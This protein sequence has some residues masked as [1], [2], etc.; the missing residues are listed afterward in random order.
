MT[1]EEELLVRS[2]VI[3]RKIGLDYYEATF[4]KFDMLVMYWDKGN[5]CDYKHHFFGLTR[6]VI[7]ECPYPASP[8]GLPRNPVWLQLMGA[9]EDGKLKDREKFLS[10]LERKITR[11]IKQFSKC[12]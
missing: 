12:T 9:I 6:E 7:C 1:K 2:L 5:T 10:K 3:M 8:D 4:G 11:T